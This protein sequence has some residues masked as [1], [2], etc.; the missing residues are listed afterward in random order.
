MIV[1]IVDPLREPVPEGWDEFVAQE[2]LSPAW[3][4]GPLLAAT[5]CAQM[6]TSMALVREARSGTPVAAMHVRYRTLYNPW[7][8]V[9]PGHRSWIGG[10]TECRMIPTYE[11]GLHFADGCDAR[12]RQEAVRVFEKAM[13][14]RL[15]LVAR[16]LAYRGVRSS[17]LPSLPTGR[18]RLRD[19]SS[20][21][22]TNEWSDLDA[23]LATLK[24]NWAKRLVKLREMVDA[25][26]T[27]RVGDTVDPD[28]AGWLAEAVRRRHRRTG[29]LWPPPCPAGYFRELAELPGTVVISHR[30]R[31]G[32]LVACVFCYD[33]GTDLYSGIWG[34]RELTEGGY[35]HL[36]FVNMLLQVELMIQRGRRSL[37]LGAGMPELKERYGARPDPRWVVVGPR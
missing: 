35:R 31:T 28:E 4:S 33:D 24:R 22:V 21:V 20:M 7:T 11:S 13:A 5:W 29:P 18:L 3:R 12:D 14:R 9:R 8:F 16:F 25:D 26:L 37:V 15:G 30:D 23:Y 32:R 10:L 2:R 34:N 36:Y 17:D 27:T 19:A 1:E 6:P